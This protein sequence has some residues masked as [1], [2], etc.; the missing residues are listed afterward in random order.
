MFVTKNL[1][2]GLSIVC[3]LPLLAAAD[4]GPV[5]RRVAADANGEVIIS[6]VSGSIDVRGWERNEVLITGHLGEDVERLDVESS[7]GRTVIKVV[8]PRGHS[9]DSD[10]E[11]DVQV[12]RGS[13]LEASV[14]SA[15]LSSRGVLGT[16]RLK[17]VSGE[18]TAD[19]AGDD[20]EMRT[21]SGDL[22][23]RGNGK[24]LRLRASSVSGNID[25]T[26]VAGTVDVVTVSGDARVNIIDATEVRGRTT[27]G[28]LD[29]NAKLLRDGRVDVEGVSGDIT[30]RVSAPGGLSAEIESFSGDI[31]GCLASNVE[32][33]SKYGPGVR[34]NLRTVEAGARVRAKTLSGDVDICDR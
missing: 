27:S 20:S 4:E 1:R 29:L 17:S 28:S 18:I 13:R 33:V 11:L 34:L 2:A 23:L 31:Q 5:E 10:V 16:Q 14:V 12:P 7:G 22:T 6:N 32:Q 8:L 9:D 25:L 3:L 19:I 24:P 21:V 15:D 30:L 26:N